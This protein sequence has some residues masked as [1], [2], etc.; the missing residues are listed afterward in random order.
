MEGM[1]TSA[2]DVDVAIRPSGGPRCLTTTLVKCVKPYEHEVNPPRWML[3][4]KNA[5]D[6][7]GGRTSSTIGSITNKPGRITKQHVQCFE[8]D[9]CYDRGGTFS[10]E[11]FSERRGS[12]IQNRRKKER[13]F[14]LNVILVV[15]LV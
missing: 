11:M 5:P 8:T 9:A 4:A 1:R 13:P 10:F 15:C 12:L 2:A 6:D 14:V 3:F 7:R